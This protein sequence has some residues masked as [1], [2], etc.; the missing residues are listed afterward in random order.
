MVSGIASRSRSRTERTAR[1]EASGSIFRCLRLVTPKFRRR[2]RVGGGVT[3]GPI[4]HLGK[5]K[6]QQNRL[7]FTRLDQ[8]CKHTSG[9]IYSGSRPKTDKQRLVR[10]QGDGTF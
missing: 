1:G 5:A 3:R 9:R 8:L 2:L 7:M 4:L 10:R 6:I